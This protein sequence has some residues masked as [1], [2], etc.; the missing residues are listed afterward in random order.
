MKDG[1]V[2]RQIEAGKKD[3]DIEKNLIEDGWT[4]N[5]AKKAIASA[6]NPPT[7]NK[8]PITYINLFITAVLGL[9][10]LIISTPNVLN[11]KIGIAFDYSKASTSTILSNII[12]PS[13]C[14]IGAIILFVVILYQ[15]AIKHHHPKLHAI[16]YLVIASITAVGIVAWFLLAIRIIT[17]PSIY[18]ST[19]I[20]IMSISFGI[21]LMTIELIYT[22]L[23]SLFDK[24]DPH[25]KRAFII[26]GCAAIISFILLTGIVYYAEQIATT[27]AG[28]KLQEFDKIDSE[29]TAQ[30]VSLQEEN[31]L[32]PNAYLRE[33]LLIETK[34]IQEMKITRYEKKGVREDFFNDRLIESFM[35][36]NMNRIERMVLTKHVMEITTYYA[37][38]KVYKQVSKM[39]IVDMELYKNL[40]SDNMLSEINDNN[41]FGKITLDDMY[42]A[43]PIFRPAFLD[44]HMTNA[45]ALIKNSQA[46][47]IV[48][49]QS[50]IFPE[51]P[52]LN[53]PDQLEMVQ[54]RIWLYQK[55]KQE[56]DAKV[57]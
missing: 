30:L 35:T 47:S 10:L 20:I 32:L 43:F 56:Q 21:Y 12:I 17:G 42:L 6:R 9:F 19:M 22:N 55:L 51:Y 15:L 34:S 41:I 49:G 29:L 7:I 48:I 25:I 3:S 37:E 1:W 4:A 26:A 33:K 50:R 16:F 11:N 45:R 2:M 36:E 28:D 18:I 57:K 24:K 5:D 13:L 27:Y 46:L 23:R 40:S 38:F 52:D 8:L 44:N 14:I 53:N 39:N 54:F 31:T